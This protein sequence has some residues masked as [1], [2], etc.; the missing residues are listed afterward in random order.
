MS[1]IDHGG[2]LLSALNTLPFIATAVLV[3]IPRIIDRWGH[4]H[5]GKRVR[6]KLGSRTLDTTGHSAKEAT[7]ILKALTLLQAPLQTTPPAPSTD[8]SDSSATLETAKTSRRRNTRT[9]PR[10][11]Q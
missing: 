5:D 6:L 11:P 1:Q 2:V 7:A 9:P 8:S 3:G 4:R 10:S